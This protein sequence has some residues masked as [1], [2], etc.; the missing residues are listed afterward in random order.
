[1]GL[2]SLSPALGM[3]FINT[4]VHLVMQH[5]SLGLLTEGPTDKPEILIPM[6]RPGQELSIYICLGPVKTADFMHPKREECIVINSLIFVVVCKN[7]LYCL[8]LGKDYLWTKPASNI[9]KEW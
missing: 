1:M 2:F 6:P 7:I 5:P 9:K 4:N 8:H 3:I